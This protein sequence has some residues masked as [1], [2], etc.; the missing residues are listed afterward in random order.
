VVAQTALD[1]LNSMRGN[2]GVHSGISSPSATVFGGMKTAKLSTASLVHGQGN[3]TFMSGA[4][5]LSTH[6]LA[7]VGNDT[8]VGGSAA[9]SAHANTEAH[10]TAGSHAFALN[11]DTINVKG[12]TAEAVKSTHPDQGA[13]SSHTITL[14]DKTTVTISGLQHHDAGILPH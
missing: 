13:T 1:R 11:S 3:D 5:S 6:A 4:R 2:S 12:A 9:T 14:G 10:G 7:H 8:V